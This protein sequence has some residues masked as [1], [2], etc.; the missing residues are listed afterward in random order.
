MARIVAR[1]V[2]AGLLLL[3]LTMPAPAGAGAVDQRLGVAEALHD[4]GVTDELGAGWSR[5]VIPWPQVQPDGPGDFSHL[6]QTLP[7]DGLRHELARGARVVGLLEFTPAWAAEN[8]EQGQRS[9]PRNLERPFDDPDNYFG[10]YVMRT[11]ER[12]AGRIDDW[13]IWNEPEFKP[14]DAG[15]GGSYTWLGTDD[16]FARLLK[17][18]YLAAKRA[19]PRA[20]VVF[21][22]TS[23]WIDATNGRPQYYDRLLAILAA[24]PAAAANDYYHDALGLNLYRAADDVWRVYSLFKGIQRAHGIDKPIWLTETNAMPTDDARVAC[25]HADDPIKTTM[26]QQAAYGIQA[27]AL[28]A[29]A[30]YARMELYQTVDDDACAQPAL[31]GVA[32][33]DGS[34]RPVARALE[35][36]ID[37]LAGYSRA[38]FVP[39]VR[40]GQA[41]SPWPD[42]PDSLV[43]NWQV[44]QVAFDKPGRRR[45]TVVWNGDGAGLRAR[46]KKNG[47]SARAVDGQG[48]GRPLAEEQGWWVVDL[49][50]A[51][52][53]F[54]VDDR[55]TDP[56]GY[57]FIGGDPVFV[58]EEGVDPEAPVVAPALG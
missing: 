19:N 7:E 37:Q 58:V 40:D 9:P 11:V 14:G 8:P 50:P 31:W 13:V 36:T 15:A 30:G 41:W 21:P 27:F 1:A 48:D 29:A 55:L 49:P 26:A 43:P 54:H 6:G 16:Q 20:T 5:V 22:G 51:T 2:V 53:Y 32:R 12:Y 28:A 57:Q 23:Y 34:R 33:D 46:I 39:L 56:V 18:G 35:T 17:V 42:D 52:A 44:Y 38:R 24:D 47:S 25:P 10:Q 45:V 4:T 3:G